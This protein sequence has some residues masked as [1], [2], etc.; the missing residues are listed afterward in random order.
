MWFLGLIVGALVG[1]I[2]GGGGAF[3]GAMIGAFVGWA[4]GAKSASNDERLRTIDG[5]IRQLSERVNEL[6]QGRTAPVSKAE[7][8][9]TAPVVSA[10]SDAAPSR[11]DVAPS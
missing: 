5:A 11:T 8:L 10:A 1:A 6:E 4:F 2:G 9:D 3:I 7:K